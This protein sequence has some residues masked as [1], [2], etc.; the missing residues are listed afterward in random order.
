M[1]EHERECVRAHMFKLLW[2]KP[3]QSGSAVLTGV[4]FIITESAQAAVLAP[5]APGV[6]AAA[7]VKCEGG[8]GQEK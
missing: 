8:S 1:A 7:E 5:T 4:S 3:H 2:K 6:S